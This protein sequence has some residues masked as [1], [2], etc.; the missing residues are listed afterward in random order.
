MTCI[1]KNR[2][3]PFI[4][5][6]EKTLCNNFNSLPDNVCSNYFTVTSRVFQ[7]TYAATTSQ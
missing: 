4:Q 6:I 2:A 5:S 7:I 3:A 1:Y